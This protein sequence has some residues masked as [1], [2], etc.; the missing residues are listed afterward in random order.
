M[1]RI[2]TKSVSF[3]GLKLSPE[4]GFVLSR[5]EG[6]TTVKEL[7]ALTGLDEGRV[8]EIVARLSEVGALEVDPPP[9][10]APAPEPEP[11]EPIPAAEEDIPLEA[12]GEEETPEEQAREATNERE[13]VKLYDELYRALTP[14]ERVA[15]VT[16]ATGG[17]LCALCLAPEPQVVHAVLAHPQVTLECA[18]LVATHH[19]THV[20]LEHVA[21]R[22]DFL[23]DAI[24]QRRLLRN[25]QLPG[26]ILGRMTGSRP[27]MEVYKVAVDREIPERSR[28]M[29]REILRKK[30]MVASSDE[31]AALVFKTEGRCLVLL[32]NCSLDAHATQILCSKQ[33]YTIL[34]I[35]N[36]ARWSATPPS[37]LGHLLK[38][39]VV[40][41]NAG[42]RKMILKHP[43]T[44][45]ELKRTL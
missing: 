29:I 9:A 16:S 4:E 3:A 28:L 33:N 8:A 37:L 18:R 17:Q 42:L 40:R 11:E 21:R 15:A 13:Y 43:N 25:A 23:A 5:V 1:Q 12:G 32:V 19:R 24:V 35:Q 44:P 14:D 10:P 6:A 36:L 7:V 30:F 27:M 45:S 38:M 31:R 20:G 34:L 2:R 41:H 39:P 26:T 22:S